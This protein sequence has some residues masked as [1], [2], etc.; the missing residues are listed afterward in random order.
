KEWVDSKS[1]PT[2]CDPKDKK[3]Y[4]MYKYHKTKSRFQ[5]PDGFPDKKVV[6]AYLNPVVDSSVQLD[7]KKINRDGLVVFVKERMG[8]N[9]EKLDKYLKPILEQKNDSQ[10]LITQFFSTTK[11]AVINS[12]RLQNAVNGLVKKRKKKQ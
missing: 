6:D 5:L 4:F 8:W 9:E 10:R 12:K 2:P 7:W 3:K 11:C 1:Q